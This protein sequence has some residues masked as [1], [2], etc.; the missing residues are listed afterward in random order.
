MS[1]QE[2]K[3][4]TKQ[5]TNQETNQANPNDLT[6]QDLATMKGIIELASERSTFKPGELAAVGS[7]YNKL[8]SF[9]KAVEAQQAATKE[10][11]NKEDTLDEAVADYA[12]T[13]GK[14]K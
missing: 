9:L 5:E 11:E 1:A 4:E 7:V 12:S 13:N 8:E 14:T 6:I 2:T 10:S 3:Q